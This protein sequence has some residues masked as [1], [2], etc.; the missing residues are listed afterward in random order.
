M[1]FSFSE[2]QIL[3]RNSVRAALD[4]QCKP[5]HVRA[6][7]EDGGSGYS[8]ALW[9]E[10]A[11]LGWL[12]LPFAEEQ[13]G[14]GLGLVELALVLEEMG[15]AAYPGPYFA[16]VVLAGLGLQAGGS[17]AQKERWLPAI[18][19]GQARGTAALLEDSLDWDPAATTAT[20][21]KAG[22]GWRLGGVKRFVPWAHV[23]DVA[24][25][26]AR[27]PEGVSL[28]LV[29]PRAAGVTLTPMVGIDLANRWSEMRFADVAVPA[30]ALMGR[31]GEA[32]PVLEGLLRRAAVGASAEMLGAARRCLHM[33]VDYAKVREQF[34]QLI[35]S[36]QAIRHR[37]AEMLLEVEKAHAAVYYAA[38][39]LGAG[40]EDAT[41]AASVCKAFVSEAARQVC[42][43]AIQVHGGI[44]FTWE[45]DLHLYFKRAK[46]LEPLYGDA[47]Y[48]RELLVRGVTASA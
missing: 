38:W 35:G 42:G 3:L 9:A 33:S 41:M 30:D 27:A 21:T 40:A 46:A 39:A 20:A 17:A 14:A 19:S 12:G 44:G 31:A 2:D 10:M 11:K 13:G 48:H 24:L 16:S 47:A 32:G 26:P 36:F 43:D 25:V 22:A 8:A 23:A 5:A 45:Y 1:N 34:G 7:M 29:D 4:E 18:A 28:F 15:R 37:C 6:M